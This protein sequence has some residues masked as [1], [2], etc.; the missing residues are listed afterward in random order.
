MAKKKRS[1]LWIMVTVGALVAAGMA[2]AFWPRPAEVDIAQVTRGPMS[3]MIRE[4]ARTRVRSPYTVTAPVDGRLLRVDMEP[5]DQVEA[6]ETAVARMAPSAPPVL[7]ERSRAEARAAVTVAE[8]ALDGARAEV[9]SAEADRNLATEEL[10]RARRLRETGSTSQATLDQAQRAWN[11]ANAAYQ[12]A[13]AA[14]TM[15]QAE[16]ES[17]QVRL[18]SVGDL[19]GTDGTPEGEVSGIFS[20]RSPIS[21]TVLSIERQNAGPVMAGTAIM[22][23]GN[24]ETDLEVVAEM[25]STDAVQV[26][27][28]D[29][30]AI[31]GWGGDGSLEGV[32]SR[33]EP[34]AFTRVSALGVQEQRVNV[35]IAFDQPPDTRAGL[36][37]GFRVQVDIVVWHDD[38]TLVVPSSALF[39]QGNGW[40][41]FSV[42]DGTARLTPV[43]IG[44]NN[45]INAQILGGLDEGAVV[46][47]YPGPELEDGTKVKPRTA[48]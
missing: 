2:Y 26:S 18:M 46:I 45:G 12:A 31:G 4:E 5:G 6:G 41:V 42:V 11:A 25:L 9:E 16:L 47:P 48:A 38:D 17:A 13:L 40:S 24:I 23:I 34:G 8:A 19:I 35:I 30:V 33:V 39:R 28:G 14:I 20:L 10:D 44:R 27:I 3:V 29:H 32:V 15:R 37:S 36:G 21:G 1:R 22:Q 7:D 43:E